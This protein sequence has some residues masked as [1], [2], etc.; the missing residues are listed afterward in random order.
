[1]RR[2]WLGLATFFVL[3]IM[4]RTAIAAFA[5][6]WTWNSNQSLFA[7]LA[8][9]VGLVLSVWMTVWLR[10]G[11]D[12]VQ[13]R[14]TRLM[15]RTGGPTNRTTFLLSLGIGIVVAVALVFVFYTR[16]H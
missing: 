3:L 6:P 2:V 7:W 4:I 15:E 5:V 14:W 12:A 8:L 9:C 16:Q 10:G 1:M 11:N 13:V